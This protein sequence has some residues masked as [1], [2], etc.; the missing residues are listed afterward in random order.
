MAKYLYNTRQCVLLFKGGNLEIHPDSHKAVTE[1]DY[2]SGM[3]E[4]EILRGDLLVF[5]STEEIPGKKPPG[6][7]APLETLSQEIGATNDELKAFLAAQRAKQETQKSKYEQEAVVIDTGTITEKVS[8]SGASEVVSK[9]KPGRK[10]A[11][12]P[13]ESAPVTA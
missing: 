3:F 2:S 12:A 9:N 4:S 6:S 1:F 10:A 8:D 5:N 13:V 11:V 7:G